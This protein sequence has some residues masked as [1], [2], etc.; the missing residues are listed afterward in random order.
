MCDTGVRPE[1]PRRPTMDELPLRVRNFSE[2]VADHGELAHRYVA[3]LGRA[4]PL[5]DA[6]A[7]AV[8][9]AGGRALFDRALASP[10]NCPADVPADLRALMHDAVQDP[11]WLDRAHVEQGALAYRRCGLAVALTLS[12]HSLT[13]G[14]ESAASVK[15]LALTG[16]L[17]LRA[18]RRLAETGRFVTEVIAPGGLVPGA[19]G[20][21][22]CVRVRIMHAQVRRML[23]RSGRWDTR[24]WGAPIN[25]ADTAFTG[26]EFSSM[27]LRGARALGHTFTT[28]QSEAVMHQW[29]YVAHLLGLEPQLGEELSTEARAN[30]YESLARTMFDG[31]DEDS[32]ALASALRRAAVE[33]AQTRWQRL[34]ARVLTP[35]HDGLSW[36][37]NGPALSEALGT[38]HR[39]ARHLVPVVA[40][41]FGPVDWLR[42]RSARL[43]TWMARV[44]HRDFRRRVALG[45]RGTEPRFESVDGPAQARRSLR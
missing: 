21:A 19:E 12:A 4:D 37:L 30:R 31:P 17:E 28:E 15:P 44:G 1:G 6:A 8:G 20:F 5:G 23:L 13:G 27:M 29:R 22:M 11:A 41:L 16:Q 14:Y 3:A 7:E 2:A 33:G 43:E 40:A 25:Q 32:R 34:E 10:T 45:L 36:A 26:L 42:R 24:A 39:S 9:G 38:P 35:L 18:V